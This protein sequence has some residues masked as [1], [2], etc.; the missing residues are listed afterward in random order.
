M[1]SVCEISHPLSWAKKIDSRGV[2]RPF[3]PDGCGNMNRQQ[4]GKAY[5][6]NGAVYILRLSLLERLNTYYSENT[7]GYMMPEERSLDIDTPFDFEF[8]EFLMRKNGQY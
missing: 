2:L 7:F 1:I 4:M 6:P 8:A 3:L 5:M